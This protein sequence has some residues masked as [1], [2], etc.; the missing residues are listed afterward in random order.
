MNRFF[1]TTY[2]HLELP[3][4]TDI[5]DLIHHVHGIVLFDFITRLSVRRGIDLIDL[6]HG[7]VLLISKRG[8]WCYAE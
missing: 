7:I 5:I 4:Q 3:M 2:L 6:I 8:S 1:I